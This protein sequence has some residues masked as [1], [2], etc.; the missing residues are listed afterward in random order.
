DQALADLATAAGDLPPAARDLLKDLLAADSPEEV[1][2]LWDD[3]SP[4]ERKALQNSRPEIIGNLDGVP[5]DV[6]AKTNES[7]LKDLLASDDLDAETRKQLEAIAGE[8]KSGSPPP[9][10]ISFDPDG[11][12]QVTAALAYNDLDSAEKINVLVPGMK[13]N[14]EG[15]GPWGTTAQ[16]INDEVTDSA[17]VVWFGYDSPNATEETGMG[18][19]EDGAAA[20][21]GFLDGIDTLS[22]AATTSVVAHSYGTTTAAQAIGSEP[23]GHGVDNFITVGSAGLPNDEQVQKNLENGPQIY[24]TTSPDDHVAWVGRNA[25]VSHR[26]SPSDIPG[27]VVFGSDGGVDASG[28]PL[29]LTRG[30]GA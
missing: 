14:V 19:A 20:L 25:T 4:A 9:N 13:S 7:H 24:A 6:R 10:L 22:P 16:Q 21:G 8:L 5:Y 17:T 3:A 27:T 15:M 29:A 2:E 11:S 26:T 18:R 12:E 23:G 28:D 30:H 1:S